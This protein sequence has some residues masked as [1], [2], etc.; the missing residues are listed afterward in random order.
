MKFPLIIIIIL[1]IAGGCKT[2]ITSPSDIKLADLLAN[3]ACNNSATS[4]LDKDLSQSE[5]NIVRLFR[6]S[7]ALI[8]DNDTAAIIKMEKA[9]HFAEKSRLRATEAWLNYTLGRLYYT[10]GESSKGVEHLLFAQELLNEIGPQNFPK[11]GIFFSFLGQVYSDYG[12]YGLASTYLRKA[13][14]NDL[15]STRDTY[16]IWGHLGLCYY[17]LGKIDS[18][19]WAS[20]EA[21]KVA[22][23]LQDT[24]EIG[25]MSGNIGATYLE[26]SDLPNAFKN[27]R[28]DL[29]ISMKYGNLPSAAAVSIKLAKAYLA[30]NMPD[31]ANV[32]LMRADSIYHSC[33]CSSN[34]AKEEY[35][36]L[37]ARYSRSKGAVNS[38]MT[39]IDSFIAFTGYVKAERD[40]VVFNNMKLKSMTKAHKAQMQLK[41]SE[42]KR[43]LL[44]RNSVILISLSLLIIVLQIVFRLRQKRK[45][46]KAI[47]DI[48]LAGKEHQ[49]ANYIDNIKDKNRLLEALKY[50]LENYAK[51]SNT[52][53]EHPDHEIEVLAS[54]RNANLITEEGWQEFTVLV[55]QVHQHFFIR[56]HQKYPTLSP[57]E[58]RLITLIKLNLNIKEI[59]A[60]LGITPE[61]VRK[62]RQ[63]VRKKLNI[64]ETDELEELIRS[65]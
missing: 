32:S 29:L 64:N 55:D 13:L 65:I 57:A 17:R 3:Y 50:E 15:C 45:S 62:A 58:T 47:Y 21:L 36:Q 12:E 24:V 22:E 5:V 8:G 53:N 18:S 25:S 56:L 43:A 2:S 19:L 30:A 60:M 49:L 40:P 4:P 41:D 33:N 61:S 52:S 34:Q 27:L 10:S 59:S 37:L 16:M 44:M 46:D 35:Y 7:I 31:S 23:Y 48:T 9:L 11:M 26:K 39:Q 6:E 20:H 28:K 38:Y 42:Q 63:R 14:S 54:I 1:L 51:L